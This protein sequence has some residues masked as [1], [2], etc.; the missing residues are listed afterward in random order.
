MIGA[1][2]PEVKKWPSPGDGLTH[3]YCDGI[4]CKQLTGTN[5]QFTNGS[6]AV[7]CTDAN[8][9]ATAEVS[10]GDFIKLEADNPED[11]AEVSSIT[12]ND[13]IVLA[14]NYTGT[15]GT[16][17]GRHTTNDGTSK[18]TAY[19]HL[20]QIAG[21]TNIVVWLRRGQ[22]FTASASMAM[23]VS[24]SLHQPAW[25]IGDNDT[26][27]VWSEDS[28]NVRPI[29]DVDTSDS[30]YLM[31]KQNSSFACIV[32][33]LHFR[34]TD[35]EKA[36]GHY[37]AAWVHFVNC[38]WENCH[39]SRVS[40]SISSLIL[41]GCDCDIAA[42]FNSNSNFEYV[43]SVWARNTTFDGGVYAFAGV[44]FGYFE[45]CTFGATTAHGTAD[46]YITTGRAFFRNCA[47]NSPT[48][49][50]LI[51]YFA[52]QSKCIIQ[53]E[54][55]TILDWCAKFDQ[56]GVA[57]NIASASTT[58]GARSGG[59]TT[60]IKF[61]NGDELHAAWPVNIAQLL[62]VP[63]STGTGVV[64]VWIQ[65]DGTWASVPSVAGA[66]TDEVWVQVLAWDTATSKWKVF[67]SRDEGSQDGLAEGVWRKV[68]VSGIEVDSSTAPLI[69][70]VFSVAHE[71]DKFI[72]VDRLCDLS[73]T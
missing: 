21:G 57:E 1:C 48:E 2:F 46:M 45:N 13:N 8:G 38:R 28:G 50:S 67:D 71:A 10:A 41:D 66:N 68:R 32:A 24:G 35:D 62:K 53:D 55:G 73:V 72:H 59:A 7:S 40:G 30:Y 65:A 11:W 47:F 61:T 42:G 27:D 15:G 16:G 43:S 58:A 56:G 39:H 6:T 22:T 3:R 29:W 14:A 49:F 17:N 64:D 26:H 63:G 20:S 69:I 54:D 25:V 4:Y 12:D 31:W 9:N 5:W 60:V 23:P 36:T 18:D 33:N 34:G 52:M 51:N 44:S 19:Y 70:S 37:N